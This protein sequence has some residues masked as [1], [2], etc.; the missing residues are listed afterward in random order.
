M[1]NAGQADFCDRSAADAGSGWDSTTTLA[2]HLE[3]YNAL[4]D[5]GL[6]DFFANPTTRRLLL[7]TGVIAEDG[8]I[9]ALDRAFARVVVAERNTELAVKD[10]EKRSD[11]AAFLKAKLRS[12]VRTQHEQTARREQV[13]HLR[14]LELERL[15]ARHQQH[16]ELMMKAGVKKRDDDGEDQQEAERHASKEAGEAPDEEGEARQSSSRVSS[17]DSTSP[18][19]S[20]SSPSSRAASASPARTPSATSSR[21]SASPA[22]S[23]DGSQNDA[24]AT[25]VSSPSSS[26]TGREGSPPPSPS[27]SDRSGVATPTAPAAAQS[28]DGGGDDYSGDYEDEDFESAQPSPRD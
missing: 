25:P 12:R 14:A 4:R 7:H 9:V 13:Q 24:G 17:R 20:S 28:D 27:P 18:S 15:R 2:K 11:E 22:P 19:S 8:R 1:L 10:E 23:A 3:D 26:A 16:E 21:P 5:E 6:A